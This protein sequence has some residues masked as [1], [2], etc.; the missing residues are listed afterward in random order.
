MRPRSL[1]LGRTTNH[2]GIAL[3]R[4]VNVFTLKLALFDALTE[5]APH[6]LLRRL[7][8]IESHWVELGC[9]EEVDSELN[10]LI[11]LGYSLLLLPVEATPRHS[12]DAGLRHVH[13]RSAELDLLQRLV[14]S[15]RGGHLD[16][17]RHG[18]GWGRVD[19]SEAGGGRCLP[20]NLLESRVLPPPL[21]ESEF[22]CCPSLILVLRD[23][24]SSA[25]E[26]RSPCP[27][28]GDWGVRGLYMTRPVY[29]ARDASH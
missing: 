1:S 4:D 2:V 24:A 27:A 9:V 6:P 3:G 14:A 28:M 21:S 26:Q 23:R 12:A 29:V 5:P 19:T 10:R 7:A 13:V 8:V 16:G 25:T 17:T 20:R 22:S 11:Q 15:D 18:C